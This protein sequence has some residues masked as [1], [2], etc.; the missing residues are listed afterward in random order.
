MLVP[1]GKSARQASPCWTRWWV[2]TERNEH[3]KLPMASQNFQSRSGVPVNEPSIKRG[4][5][6]GPN[7]RDKDSDSENET[8]Q[9]AQGA[10]LDA[11][12]R[13]L[14]VEGADPDRPLSK[15]SPF[16]IAKF[17]EGVSSGIGEVRRLRGGSFLVKCD[18][19]RASDNLLKR[20][21]QV[22]IDRPINVSVHRSL[23]SSKGVIRCR[24]LEG[25]SET[26]IRSGLGEQGV[27]DVHRVTV[28]K[29]N[30]KM[31]TN[32]FFLT[33]CTQKLPEFVKVGYL[34]VPVKMFVPSPLRCFK[35]HRYGHGAQRCQAEE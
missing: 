21:G 12:P 15:L 31:P 8:R 23:N 33:F 24:E 30:D 29:G 20:D 4:R 27:T 14:V 34:R 26:D 19:K 25:M 32:T 6:R 28:R 22:C 11:W 17:F 3:L 9:M 7:S 2:G 18:T 5:K 35:C 1:A 16:A 13:F 10:S